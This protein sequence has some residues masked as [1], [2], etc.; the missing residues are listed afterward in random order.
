MLLPQ[1]IQ[2]ILYHLMMG[3]FYGCTFSFLCSLTAYIRFTIGKGC[4]EIIFHVGFVLL[5]FYGLYLINGGVTN[6]YLI[7]F[8]LLGVIVYYKWYCPVFIEVFAWF[9]HLF[10]PLHRK[11][12]LVKKKIL[13][14][15]KVSQKKWKKKR[16]T[17]GRRK[18]KSDSLEEKEAISSSEEIL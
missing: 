11:V 14:I 9:R 18:E 1:Q 12:A 3:W 6:Y 4:L 16:R 10:R 7:V 5:A 15:I 17:H 13:G 8:F 2:A